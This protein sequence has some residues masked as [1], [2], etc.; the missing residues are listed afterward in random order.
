MNWQQ[1]GK[2]IIGASLAVGAAGVFAQP[3]PNVPPTTDG[4]AQSMEN[5]NYGVCTGT[6]PSCYH[7]WGVARA[8]PPK[9]L[10]F[11]R[12]AGPRHASIGTA[13]PAGLNP[14]ARSQ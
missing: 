6:D 8:N 5:P 11:T 1:V 12:T 2:S 13:L 14:P 10:L 9:V 4:T 7:N 3:F